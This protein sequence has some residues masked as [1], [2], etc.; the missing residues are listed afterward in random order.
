MSQAM[1]DR[2]TALETEVRAGIQTIRGALIDLF[3]SVGADP[4]SPQ[5]VARTIG[6]NR[7]LAWKLSKLVGDEELLGTIEHLP[8]GPGLAIMLDR[9]ERAGAP[10]SVTARVREAME[11]FDRTVDVHVGDRAT[12]ELM[13]G[14]ML[15]RHLRIER[16]EAARKLAFSGMSVTWG[17]QARVR[18]ANTFYAPNADDPSMID[19]ANISALIGYR[20]LRAGTSWPLIHVHGYQGDGTPLD[21]RI[22]PLDPDVESGEPPLLRA[23]CRG[24]QPVISSVPVPGG[25]ELE[26]GEGP[27]GNHGR[28]TS[29][30]GQIARRFA[31]CYRDEVNTTGEQLV[32][33]FTPVENSVI[34]MI[35]HRALPFAMPPSFNV[36]GHLTPYWGTPVSQHRREPLPLAE[37]VQHL[38]EGPPML[39]TSLIPEYTA[40]TELVYE[41]LGWDPRDFTAYRV[42][43]KYPPIPSMAALS[44]PLAERPDDGA[45]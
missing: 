43:V 25:I 26:V 38:G 17:I 23:F 45:P 42:I 11:S 3:A 16:G 37:T 2:S 24:E 20:R 18:L 4:T 36:Y 14:H 6:I 19:I 8:G 28:L 39:A 35:V 13:L 32:Q 12:L 10:A 34:D 31:S 33:W 9:F 40:M 21:P 29:V 41:R 22:E 44:F 27:L 5:V 15:P 7:N 30:F 1:S